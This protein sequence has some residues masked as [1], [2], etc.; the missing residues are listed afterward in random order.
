MLNS[1]SFKQHVI[2]APPP[3]PNGDLHV[4]H[5]AGPYFGADVLRRYVK[6]RRSSAICALS[7]DLYQSYVV[8][9]AE[10]LKVDPVALARKS[11][12]DITETLCMSGIEFDVFGMPDADYGA[13]VTEWFRQLHASGVLEKRTRAIPYDPKRER[14]LFESYASGRCPVC[15]AG[16]NGNICEACGH[17]NDAQQLFGLHPTGG[18]VGDRLESREVTEYILPLEAFRDTLWEH[19]K[20]KVPERRPMLQRLLNELFA[21]PLP[22]FPVTFKS[23][24][25][26]PAP[27]PGA[28]GL[29]INVWAEMV[30]GHYHWLSQTTTCDEALLR[31]KGDARYV[32]FL[33]FD[34]SFFY[35][36][37]QL[38]LALAARRAGMDHLLPGAFVTNEFY[39][40]EN[41]KFSTSQGHLI[42][43]RDMLADVDRDELRFYLAWS[44]P[45]YNQANFSAADFDK[46]VEKKLRRPFAALIQELP[47]SVASAQQTRAASAVLDRFASA[48]APESFSLRTA[49]QSIA[50]GLELALWADGAEKSRIAAALAIGMAPIMPDM[51][52]RLWAACGR[53]DP[54]QWP[55]EF[56][57]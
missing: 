21:R 49:A 29:V 17:P 56:R 34:N 46:V 18:A 15:L 10:R 43:A 44:N 11:H 7:V 27:F 33:G 39:L 22:D 45:E 55:E 48:Y 53:Y 38:A 40:L 19:L 5:I 47:K 51:A 50:N 4:G 25:G 31:G 8:T 32:Q 54:L 24:W 14:F 26:L 28:E 36:V 2:V 35:C 23:T 37:A 42:W 6:L 57:G 20:N 52:E 1:T 9:T 30:P 12:E 16:T 13:Y 41:F 3:T